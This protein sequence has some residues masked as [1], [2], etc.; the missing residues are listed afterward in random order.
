M[1]DSINKAGKKPR[2]FAAIS[3]EKQRETASK[4]G[5]ASRGGGRTPKNDGLGKADPS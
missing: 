3:K 1:P 2:G 5:K 4:G